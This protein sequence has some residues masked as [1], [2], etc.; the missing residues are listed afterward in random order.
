[1]SDINEDQPPKRKPGR[2]PG[3]KN[4]TSNGAE[5]APSNGEGHNIKPLTDEQKQKLFFE[6]VASYQKALKK[7]KT[8]QADL[9]NVGKVIKGEGTNL[10]DV[11][12][13]IAL[14]D[15]D[16]EEALRERIQSQLKVAA[17]LGLPIGYQAGLFSALPEVSNSDQRHFE[18]GKRAGLKG[19]S[20]KPPD[21]FG[22][23]AA[24]HWLQGYHVGQA[25]IL[26]KFKKKGDG[27]DE[28]H[29]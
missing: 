5:A 11:K 3:S 26:G 25:V 17:W 21:H 15:P 14:E 24:D 8:A 23:A 1:M 7:F 10:A 22:Q 9:K 4:K 19:E 12:L 2:P 16:Q 13:A 29:A 18:D 20:A 28:A 27:G 6:H